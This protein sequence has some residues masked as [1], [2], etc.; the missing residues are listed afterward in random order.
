MSNHAYTEDQLAEHPTTAAPKLRVSTCVEN[1][2]SSE[3]PAVKG[4]FSVNEWL[5]AMRCKLFI[6]N[7]FLFE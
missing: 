7:M 1:H 3:T 2:Y 5:P 6:P 4:G